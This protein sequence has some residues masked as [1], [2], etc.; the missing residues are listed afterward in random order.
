MLLHLIALHGAGMNAQ[1]WGGIAPHMAAAGYGAAF[2]PLNLPGHRDHDDAA[3]LLASIAD[4]ATWL[5]GRIDDVPADRDIVLLGHSMGAAVALAAADHARVRGVVAVNTGARMPVNADLL[6]LAQSDPAS[7]QAMIIKWSCDSK[8]P[9]AEAVRHVVA[10][11]MQK[12]PAATLGVDL[13]ACNSMPVVMPVGKKMLVI[14]GRF[15]KMTPVEQVKALA[16]AHNGEHVIIDGGH[17][18]PCE[19]APEVAHAITAFLAG[20]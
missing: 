11:V 19:H 16:Q 12:T 14:S 18:L 20:L 7:A 8:H 1:I 15:D 2:Q 5:K 4:M 9:Q 6:A 10:Q 17:M 3:P 13:A